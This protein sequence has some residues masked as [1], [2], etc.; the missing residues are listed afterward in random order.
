MEVNGGE[1]LE[2][3]RKND[4][5]GG[6]VERGGERKRWLVDP[7]LRTERQTD[8]LGGVKVTRSS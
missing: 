1:E 5:T 8:R 3:E 4:R 6:K 2:R 7:A